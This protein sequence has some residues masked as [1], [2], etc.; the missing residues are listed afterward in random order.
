MVPSNYIMGIISKLKKLVL[1]SVIFV[2][3]SFT[4]FLCCFHPQKNQVHCKC[5]EGFG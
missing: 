5:K 1:D 2:S 3:D 4:F